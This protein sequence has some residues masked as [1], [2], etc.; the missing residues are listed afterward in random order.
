M[1]LSVEASILLNRRWRVHTSS[2]NSSG[3]DGRDRIVEKR[4]LLLE[5]LEVIFAE[6][7]RVDALLLLSRWTPLG[8]DGEGSN[9]FAGSS[10]HSLVGSRRSGSRRSVKKLQGVEQLLLVIVVHGGMEKV[11][12]GQQF[13]D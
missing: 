7:C 3:S 9:T 10:A 2:T 6:V 8:G 13:R 11:W 1:R 4:V 5:S 12:E